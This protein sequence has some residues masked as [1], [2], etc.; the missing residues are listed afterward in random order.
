VTKNAGSTRA[1]AKTELA[2]DSGVS[3]RIGEAAFIAVFVF[4]YNIREFAVTEVGGDDAMFSC[5][6]Q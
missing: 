1:V 2:Q 6:L 4:N 3:S 5:G